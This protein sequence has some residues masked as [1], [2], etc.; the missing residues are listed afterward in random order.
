M[1]IFCYY[2]KYNKQKKLCHLLNDAIFNLIF[3]ILYEASPCIIIF[4][5]RRDEQKPSLHIY[6]NNV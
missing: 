5:C 6:Q 1:K 2:K 3:D 4:I